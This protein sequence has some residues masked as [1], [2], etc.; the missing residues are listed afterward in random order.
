VTH[1]SVQ[2]ATS[3]AFIIIIIIINIVGKVVLS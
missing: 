2:P 3:S 1:Y